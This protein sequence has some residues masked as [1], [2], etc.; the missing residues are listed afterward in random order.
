MSEFNGLSKEEVK[1]TQEILDE[2]K[3]ETPVEA[4]PAE[5]KVEKAEE[6]KPEVKVEPEKVEPE[7]KEEEEVPDFEQNREGRTPQTVSLHKHLRLK[8]KVKNLEAEIE[9]IRASKQTIEQKDEDIEQLVGS[10]AEELSSNLGLDKEML[11]DVFG[12]FANGIISKT[13][14]PNEVAEVIKKVKE[15]EAWQ[16]EEELFNREFDS[17]KKEYPDEKLD[18]E[19]LHQM[20]FREDMSKKSL[21]EIYFRNVKPTIKE[22][23]PKKRSAE[24]SKPGVSKM[25]KQVDYNNIST[26]EMLAMSDEEFDQYSKAI[27]GK[28][29][30]LTTFDNKGNRVN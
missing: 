13:K 11:A 12:K 29:S 2:I 14:M 7:L 9:T 27:E 4:K 18:K 5:A 22:P 23:E 10:T 1:E 17:L 28:R 21:F 24:S 26:E 30:R 15:Q 6:P 25:D 20:A 16:K 3:E 8:D 19:Q